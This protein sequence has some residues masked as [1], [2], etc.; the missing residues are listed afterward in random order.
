MDRRNALVIDP[1][2]W[3][4]PY[5][6]LPVRVAHV[7]RLEGLGDWHRDPFDRMLVAQALTERFTL[8]SK[9]AA[10]ARYAPVVW[11]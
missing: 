11:E 10:L 5:E 3:S 8:A 2:A 1:A 9:D 7:D 4:Q 6:V